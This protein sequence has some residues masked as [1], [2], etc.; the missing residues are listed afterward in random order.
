MTMSFKDMFN[1]AIDS[2]KG[3]RANKGTEDGEIIVLIRDIRKIKEIK[4]LPTISGALCLEVY[5]M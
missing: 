1:K 4:C 5:K 3:K 2:Y